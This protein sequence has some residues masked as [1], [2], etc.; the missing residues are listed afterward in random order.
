[1]STTIIDFWSAFRAYWITPSFKH[2]EVDEVIRS[3]FWLYDW[4]REN[5][6]GQVIYLDQFSRHFA[7]LGLL[8]EIQVLSYRESACAL[9]TT[10]LKELIEFDEVELVFALMPF[11]HLERFDFI[12]YYIHQIWLHVNKKKLCDC[13]DLM[14]FYMDTYKKAYTLDMVS[15]RIITKHDVKTYE[16]EQASIQHWRAL[17]T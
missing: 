4:T 2:K 15:S 10:R 11:K 6:I 1:M 14:R 17:N 7:R 3:K 13:P 16:P 5:L 9:V 8:D 12:F